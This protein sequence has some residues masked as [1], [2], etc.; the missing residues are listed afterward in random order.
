MPPQPT[1]D[2]P[3]DLEPQQAKEACASFARRLAER[4]PLQIEFDAENPNVFALQIAL[5]CKRSLEA[6]SCFLGFGPKAL[7]ALGTALRT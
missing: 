3:A 1:L 5:S 7:S 4:L 6:E 2:I